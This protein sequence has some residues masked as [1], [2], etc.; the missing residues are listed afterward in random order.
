MSNG[1]RFSRFSCLRVETLVC[2][3]VESLVCLTVE[4][5]VCLRVEKLVGLTRL[6]VENGD[7]SA[8]LGRPEKILN[9]EQIFG[10]LGMNSGVGPI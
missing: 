4:K 2:L 10:E 5:L 6:T 9:E 7:C 1:K 3:T 8:L